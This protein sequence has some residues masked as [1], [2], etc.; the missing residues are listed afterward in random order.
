MANPTQ[1]KWSPFLQALMTEDEVLAAVGRTTISALYARHEAAIVETFPNCHHTKRQIHTKI[2][3]MHQ[4]QVFAG[5]ADPDGFLTKH[6][7]GPGGRGRVEY[8]LSSPPWK[9]FLKQLCEDDE[10]LSS[11]DSISAAEFFERHKEAILEHRPYRDEDSVRDNVSH[12]LSCLTLTNGQP[13]SNFL[14][15]TGDNPIKYSIRDRCPADAA[16]TREENAPMDKPSITALLQKEGLNEYIQPMMELGYAFEACLTDAA[17][18]ELEGTAALLG[19][20]IPEIRRLKQA[21]GCWSPQAPTTEAPDSSD[22]SESDS[23]SDSEAQITQLREEL[24]AQRVDLECDLT[25]LSAQLEDVKAKL[26]E[27]TS[28]ARVVQQAETQTTPPQDHTANANY[29]GTSL[30][31]DDTFDRD[32]WGLTPE[33]HEAGRD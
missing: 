12:A 33:F 22:S 1:Q 8:S 16:A 2:L 14:V 25:V 30:R 31:V 20:R 29:G 32:S 19:M 7:G 4:A 9:P 10:G 17:P 13:L 26:A 11:G 21:L 24:H 23:D 27:A 18:E 5:V 15:Q 28:G 3:V 6:G